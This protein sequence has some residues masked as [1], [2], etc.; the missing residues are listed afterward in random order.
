MPLRKREVHAPNCPVPYCP[1]PDY[2]NQLIAS[3]QSNNVVRGEAV[4]DW[5]QYRGPMI[6]VGGGGGVIS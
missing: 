3:L 4:K 6:R 2:N 5:L 1:T